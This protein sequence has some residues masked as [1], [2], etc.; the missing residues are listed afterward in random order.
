MAITST[1]PN[2]EGAFWNRADVAI[3]VALNFESGGDFTTP[4]EATTTRIERG[5]IVYWALAGAAARDSLPLGVA[6]GVEHITVALTKSTGAALGTAC[7][8]AQHFDLT[9]VGEPDQKGIYVPVTG[10]QALDADFDSGTGRMIMENM[11]FENLLV[12]FTDA[13]AVVP[14]ATEWAL[15]QVIARG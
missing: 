5:G 12:D 2:P 9:I 14:G 8:V 6:R 7:F 4:I 10:K 1:V 15:L 3:N 13:A 11:G